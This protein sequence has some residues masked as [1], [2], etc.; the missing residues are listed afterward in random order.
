MMMKVMI[1][2]FF[3][4]SVRA[5]AHTEDPLEDVKK[6][7]RDSRCLFVWTGRRTTTQ[8]KIQMDDDDDSRFRL[9]D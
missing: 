6:G 1:P 9:V 5:V 8:V 3:L 2:S 4:S 7:N